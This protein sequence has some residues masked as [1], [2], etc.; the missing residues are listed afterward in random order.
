[1]SYVFSQ[2]YV[3]IDFAVRNRKAL[4][5][6]VWE[7]NLYKYIT[8]IVQNRGHKML[9]IGGMPDHDACRVTRHPHFHWNEADRIV[10]RFGTRN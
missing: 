6:S 5:S 2:L 3:H 1:M 8:G 10:I 9:A 7:D 4:I